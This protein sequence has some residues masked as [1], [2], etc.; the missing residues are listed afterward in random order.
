MVAPLHV[1]AVIAQ[2][3]IHDDVRTGSPVENIAHQMQMVHRH[4]LDKFADGDDK[5]GSLTDVNDS[6]DDVLKVVPLV[7]L[8]AVGVKQFLDNVGVLFRQGG[9]DFGAGVF[10][11]Y[12]PTEFRQ[13]VKRNAL[14]LVQ[15]GDLSLKLFQL[16]LWVI[17]QGGELVKFRA[18]NRSGEQ[19]AQFLPHNAGAGVQN[20]EKRLVFPMH[21]GKK[22]LRAFG[23]IHNRL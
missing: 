19:I 6:G 1:H 5:I 13:A 16:F 4:A 20:V 18:G 17:N 15:I 9:A 12:Q 11:G 2:Q 8:V 7:R 23:E 22:M 3:G 21:I 14:P 10:G